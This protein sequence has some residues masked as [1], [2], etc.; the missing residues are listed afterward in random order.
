MSDSNFDSAPSKSKNDSSPLKR[1]K[2]LFPFALL[3]SLIGPAIAAIVM[4]QLD[5]FDAAPIP[6]THELTHPPLTSPL[7]N[8]RMLLGAEMVG[9]GQLPGPEDIAYDSKSRVIFTGCYDGWVKRVT[10]NDSV[11]DSVVERWVNTGGRPLGVAVGHN[12]EVIVADAYRGLLNISRDGEVE[13]LTD[14]A[15]GVKFKLTDHLDIADNGVI[16]FTDASYKY[17]FK[18]YMLD[19]LEGRPYGRFMSFDPA[20]KRTTV[21]VSDL[22]FANGV[23]VS[24]DQTHV[25]FCETPMRRC[26][27]YYIEGEKKGRLEKFVDNLPGLPDNIR[28]DGEGLYWI[29]LPTAVTTPWN[30]ATKYPFVRKVVAMLEKMKLRPQMETNSGVFAVDVE[31]KPIAYYGDVG[32]KLISSGIKIGSH[33]YCG[34]L[35]YPHIIRLNLDQHPARPST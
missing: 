15:D 27:R 6:L 35:H 22:Y 14:E 31:G 1:R 9:A 19:I 25:I 10:V 32:L 2:S 24:P 23:A 8:N 12:D 11:G 33:L 34:S 3:F 17:N 28:Y 5:E 20:T 7:C 18:D 4:Y 26:R 21:L 16:Y 13:L 30:I 29:A